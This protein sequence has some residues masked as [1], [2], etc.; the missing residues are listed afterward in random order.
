MSGSGRH[1]T[2]QGPAPHNGAPGLAVWSKN[3]PQAIG[4]R[5]TGSTCLVH[6]AHVGG[7]G[8]GCGGGCVVTGSVSRAPTH[9][10]GLA[11][12]AAPPLP[13][14]SSIL[15]GPQET[16]EPP[17]KK[18]PAIWPG[19]YGFLLLSTCRP[20]R[21]QRE[22]VRGARACRPPGTRW[23]APWRRRWR[24]SPGRCGSPWRGR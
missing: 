22:R 3:S 7:S 6:A 2:E 1:I 10:A 19:A 9:A 23:S 18:P 15:R 21:G 11:H 5:G 12:S 14:K 8:S 17:R 16:P 4:L 20:C 13:T 24:R